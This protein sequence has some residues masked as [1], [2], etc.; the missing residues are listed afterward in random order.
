MTMAQAVQLSPHKTGFFNGVA[1]KTVVTGSGFATPSYA[2]TIYEN[3]SSG[4]QFQSTAGVIGKPQLFS[5]NKPAII[6]LG[7][8]L[9]GYTDLLP[10]TATMVNIG[11][12]TKNYYW[13]LHP[14]ISRTEQGDNQ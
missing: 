3:S 6:G 2:S 12:A 9:T 10:T 14:T 5:H 11:A 8:Y 4:K 1:T 13:S 7:H